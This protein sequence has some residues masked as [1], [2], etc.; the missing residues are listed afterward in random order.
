MDLATQIFTILKQPQLNYLTQVFFSPSL[1]YFFCFSFNYLPLLQK[2]LST[3]VNL[4]KHIIYSGPDTFYDD[5]LFWALSIDFISF[6][7]DQCPSLLHLI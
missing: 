2:V 5:L 3:L 1:F 4:S 6:D 7:I